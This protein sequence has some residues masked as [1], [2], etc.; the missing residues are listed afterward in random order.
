VSGKAAVPL[1]ITEN[2][3]AFNDYADPECGVDDL[4]RVDTWPTTSVPRWLPSNPGWTCGLLGL[5]TDGHNF[6]WADGYS[7]RFG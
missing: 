1:F 5:V 4:E 6:E 2:G 7:R 3:A